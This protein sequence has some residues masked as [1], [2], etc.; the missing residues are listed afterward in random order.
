MKRTHVGLILV[1]CILSGG[2]SFSSLLAEDFSFV[3]INWNDDLDT[4]RKKIDQSG[5]FRDSRLTGL[6]IESQPL[7][8]FLFGSILGALLGMFFAPKS[9]KQLRSKI[10]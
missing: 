1:I 10:K 4:V 2:L 5:L 6:Q 9:G 7:M 8:G 3:G